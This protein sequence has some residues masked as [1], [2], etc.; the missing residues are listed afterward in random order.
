MTNKGPR[1]P[2]RR[3]VLLATA[4]M[5]AA[6]GAPAVRAQDQW[7]ESRG[8]PSGPEGGWQRDPAYRVG[9]YSGGFEKTYPHHVI[10]AAA[11][12]RPLHATSKQR[13]T[14]RWGIFEKTP[15]EYLEQWSTTG[16]LICRGNQILFERYRKARSSEMRFTSFSMAKS[17]TSLLLGI[18]LDQGLIKSFDDTAQTYVPELRGTLHGSTTLRNLAN[19]SSGSAY[20][21]D[22]D[23]APIYVD[24]LAGKLS[25]SK[26]IASW[27]QRQ[28]EQGQAYNYNELC[29]LTLGMVIRQ[30][31]GTSLSKFA[32][33]NLW[34]P[35][36][37][38][39]DATWLV[40]SEGAEFN[41]VGVAARLRDWARL[42]LLVADR[43]RVGDRQVVSDSWIRECT[44]WTDKDQQCRLGRAMRSAGYKALMWHAKSDGSRPYFSGHHGQRVIIDMESRTVLAH[45]AVDHDGI[46]ERELFE[47]FDAATKV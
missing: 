34:Q 17:V 24:Y 45:T 30:V 12:Q 16:L 1:M 41:C 29:P 31:T 26:R 35:M 21:Y 7:G 39:A 27:N 18:C 5:A 14:Y 28:L 43:G 6:S 22:R 37:A 15:D 25:I 23:T 44:E 32:E 38:E 47:I 13:L 10:H 4:A 36:Q 2:T 11:G 9:N 46:W 19:M 3:D 33:A 42:G 8:Y 40:D 20:V